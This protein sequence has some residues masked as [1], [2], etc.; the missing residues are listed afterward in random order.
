MVLEDMV[1]RGPPSAREGDSARVPN[2]CEHR[3]QSAAQ[4]SPLPCQPSPVDFLMT[5]L[6]ESFGYL[7]YSTEGCFFLTLLSG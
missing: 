6:I 7:G 3:Q 1:L 2:G 4:I 5:F